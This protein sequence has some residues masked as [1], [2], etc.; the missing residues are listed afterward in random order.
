MQSI[1]HISP[2][3]YQDEFFSILSLFSSS[4]VTLILQLYDY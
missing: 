4:F 3:L 1:E 2:Q